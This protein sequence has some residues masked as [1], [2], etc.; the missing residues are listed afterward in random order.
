M[1]EAEGRDPTFDAPWHNNSWQVWQTDDGMWF[2]RPIGANGFSVFSTVHELTAAIQQHRHANR[3]SREAA[4]ANCS[5]TID[6]AIA[7]GRKRQDAEALLAD[8]GL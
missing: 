7:A 8:L 1:T 3:A 2:G 6:R 5:A 4:R